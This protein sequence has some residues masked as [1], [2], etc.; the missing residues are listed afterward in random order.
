MHRFLPCFLLLVLVV[1]S[2]AG[3]T[4]PAE[5]QG[6][7]GKRCAECHNARKRKGGLDL[8][9]LAGIAQGGRNGPIVTP[10]KP[11][12]SRLWQ[13]V[14]REKMPPDAP[15]AVSERNILRHWIEDGALG[16]DLKAA[17][18]H[19]AFRPPVRPP[20]PTVRQSDRVR[21]PVDAFILA[22]LEKKSLSLSPEGDRH[23][24]I[25][26]VSFD[27]TGLPPTPADIDR[28]VKDVSADAYER[29]VER[30]LASRHYGERWGKY[31]LDVAGYA[32]SNGYFNADSDRPLA[33]R[34]RDWVIRAFN[35]DRPYDRFVMEQLAG[36]EL[37]GYAPNGDVTL[38]LVDQLIATH[39]LRNAPDGSGESDGNPDEVRTDRFTVLEGN[40]QV[41]MNSLLGITIQCARCH[42]HKFEPISHEE[43]Y[44][45]QAI[46]FPA[47][48]PEHWVKPNDR[49][50]AIASRAQ[51]EEH[52]KQTTQ[53]DQE[54]K[55]LQAKQKDPAN[56]TKK[57]QLQREIAE[58]EKTRPKPLDK[59]SVLVDV[60]PNPPA[61][62]LLIR[63]QHN[64]PGQEV[65]PGVPAALLSPANVYH[66][67]PRPGSTGRRLGFARWVTSRENPLFARVMVSRVWQHHFGVGLVAT[68]D[69]FGQSGARPSHPELLDWLA[70]EFIDSGYSL[71]HLH[72]LIL[73]S[74]VYR[75][76]SLPRKDAL[77]GDA[78]N[79]LLSRF[80]LR[81]L[82]AEAIRDALLAVSGELDQRQGGPYV[83]SKR[84]GEGIVEIDEKHEQARRRSVYLQQRRTQVVTFLEL[85]DAPSITATCSVRNTATVPLQAL[86]LL[87]SEFVRLRA[88]AFARQLTTETNADARIRLAFRHAYGREPTDTE[89]AATTRFLEGQRKVYVSEKDGEGK[90]WIDLCQMLLASN[91]FLYVE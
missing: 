58:K 88:T 37:A 38:A 9:T 6:I 49:V 13:M 59:L 53:I 67:E 70:V 42:S 32:D 43:Y 27:L 84:T 91:A 44:S 7:L 90:T 80:P 39:F 45:L 20:I 23:T 66:P 16:I 22:E 41:A 73:S 5:V 68:P 40:L 8:S 64:K 57:E 56:A 78:D 81:R 28:F 2:A 12:V 85:F 48:N 63:G 77:A 46:L 33:W 51:R 29:M 69:N 54:I 55:E 62:R 72:R 18:T 30:Y 52:Q 17:V 71:K 50:V 36:D 61:H 34:Y 89:R 15:L 60:M 3:T 26:R 11:E 24:L 1:D 82:D 25:R 4:L 19:W 10:K 21:T 74:S 83:P 87:N 65:Q 86:S 35:A 31:W 75:Q 47:Y 14:A 76:S 79:R